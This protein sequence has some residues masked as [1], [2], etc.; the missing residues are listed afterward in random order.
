MADKI[1]TAV[2]DPDKGVQKRRGTIVGLLPQE[3]CNN[4]VVQV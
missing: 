4:Q 2:F 1:I 3:V